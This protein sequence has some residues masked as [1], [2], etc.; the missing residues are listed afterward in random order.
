MLEGCISGSIHFVMMVKEDEG[1]DSLTNS[2]T[3]SMIHNSPVTTTYIT[4]IGYGIRAQYIHV[5]VNNEL[6]ERIIVNVKNG[7]KQASSYTVNLCRKEIDLAQHAKVNHFGCGF[8]RCDF[9]SPRHV[10]RFR[11]GST[12]LNLSWPWAIA[13]GYFR[14]PVPTLK[15]EVGFLYV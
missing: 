15:P 8:F 2:L 5:K 7:G 14:L 12:L 13:C 10:I 4:W 6:I 9:G 11:W 1:S 3:N